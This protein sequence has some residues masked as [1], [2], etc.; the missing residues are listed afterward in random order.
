MSFSVYPN[1]V[2]NGV[3]HVQFASAVGSKSVLQLTD[4][5]GRIL[6]VA[7][8]SE[9]S[10]NFTFVTKSLAKGFYLIRL[11]QSGSNTVTQKVQVQ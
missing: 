2:S 3:V 4:A 6:Q 9:G 8:V 1:P 7:P 5:T 10:T 11:V